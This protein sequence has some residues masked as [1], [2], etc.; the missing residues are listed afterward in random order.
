MPKAYSGDLRERVIEAVE[1]EGASRRERLSSQ[2]FRASIEQFAPSCHN[3]VLE[4]VP[5]TSGMRAML[6]YDRELLLAPR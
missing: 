3:S 6:Q 1:I 2:P 5:T 4:N